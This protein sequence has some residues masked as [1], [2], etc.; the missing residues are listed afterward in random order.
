MKKLTL[1]EIHDAGKPLITPLAH[2][3]LSARL[4]ARAGFPSFNI[5]GSS[6]L[7]ARHALPDLGLAG[8]GEMAA[9]IQDVVQ[10]VDIP[11]IADADDGYGDVKNV[12]HTVETYHRIGVRGVLIE[13][14]ARDMKRPGAQA[15]LGVAPIETIEAKLCAAL[16]ARPD[17]D[18][19][20]IGRTDAAGIEGL[21]AALRRAERF[22]KLGVDGIFV[23]GLKTATDF[24]KVGAAFRGQWNMTVMPEGGR[25]AWQT[26]Q[27]LHAFGFT[28]VVYPNSLILS[29][30]KALEDKL[31]S[32]RA[33]ADGEVAGFDPLE[34][35]ATRAFEDAVDLRR[36]NG[37]ETESA[38][39]VAAAQKAATS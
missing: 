33:L 31:D 37:I 19:I 4:I 6:L 17:G 32:I 29:V 3:A 12:V 15:A 30:V 9:A 16:N 2:D 38:S 25:V 8:M 22:L 21:D 11:C 18:F 36:W 28:Q 23:A 26:P 20:V 14:Q 10:A 24:E 34:K 5:G 7:A 39:A 35:L 1:R 13:D 27:Q